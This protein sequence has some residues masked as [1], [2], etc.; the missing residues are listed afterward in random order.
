MS[1]EG[2]QRRTAPYLDMCRTNSDPSLKSGRGTI[3]IAWQGSNARVTV[4][5]SRLVELQRLWVDGRGRRYP[6]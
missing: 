1:Y 4:G 5:V 3:V 6:I 2:R